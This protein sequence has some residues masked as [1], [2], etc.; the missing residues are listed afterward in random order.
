MP[1][2][3]R[4]NAIGCL[5]L[6]FLIIPPFFV[7]PLGAAL[8]FAGVC[9]VIL[10]LIAE[11]NR[12]VGNLKKLRETNKSL[13]S[14]AGEGFVEFV[15]RIKNNT[16][17]HTWL[18]KRPVD[19]YETEIYQ[20]RPGSS[21]NKGNWARL[22]RKSSHEKFLTISDGSDDCFVSLH[23][24]TIHFKSDW[25]RMTSR[26]LLEKLTTQNLE[27]FPIND[28]DNNKKIK[29]VEHYV[30]A[31]SQLY[32]YGILNKVNRD[33]SPQYLFDQKDNK[34]AIRSQ[35]S[36]AL[37]LVD[38]AQ[39]TS[40]SSKNPIKILSSDYSPT[41]YIENLIV[42]LKGDS[43]I[44][45]RTYF[46]IFMCFFVIAALIAIYLLIVSRAYPDLAI[47]VEQLLSDR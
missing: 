42:S 15:A 24:S 38:W 32:F 17:H 11:I 22:Y 2:K 21:S 14:N 33:T 5:L 4:S 8:G 3:N 30:P 39:M 18:R 12:Q 44:Q 6:L 40:S 9:T 37:D 46:G 19:Y 27:N 13:I 29:V 43:N 35:S 45:L 47:E 10:F 26:Q 36:Y 23:H 28:L 7:L 16:N 20:W 41:T 31:S 1:A 25:K 34:K